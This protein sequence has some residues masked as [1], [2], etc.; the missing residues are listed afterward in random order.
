MLFNEKQ[1]FFHILKAPAGAGSYSGMLLYKILQ[2]FIQKY[3][4][5]IRKHIQIKI[6]HK[7]T[8][9]SETSEPSIRIHLTDVLKVAKYSQALD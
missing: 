9:N 2:S 1:V 8:W 7:K 5:N 3:I 6:L 4:K